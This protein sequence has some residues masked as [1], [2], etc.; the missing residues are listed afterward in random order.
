MDIVNNLLLGL[1]QAAFSFFCVS[2]YLVFLHCFYDT[3]YLWHKKK[4]VCLA[5]CV[6]LEGLLAAFSLR[7][8]SLGILSSVISLVSFLLKCFLVA[9][10]YPGKKLRA[11][12][13]F[14]L[15]STIVETC[16]GM[17][18][19]SGAALFLPE[20]LYDNFAWAQT[21]DYF[22]FS[23][24]SYALYTAIF[25]VIFLYLYHRLY[26]KGITVRCGIR[27]LIFVIL[28]PIVCLSICGVVL[29]LGKQSDLT[30]ILLTAMSMLLAI[31]FP[32]FVYYTRIGQYYRE[33]T[34]CQENYMQEELAHFTQYKLAQEETAR[35]RHDIRNNLLCLNDMLQSDETD[36]AR[37]YLREL[38][39]VSDTLRAKFVSGDEMLDCIVGVKAGI[40]EENGIRFQ[41]DGVLAGGLPWKSVDI[42]V[43]FA[44]ALDNAIEAC[45][46]LPAEDRQIAM[47]IK[48]TPQFWFVSITNP[49]KDRV[50]TDKLFR[51]DSGYT[52]KGDTRHHGI[53]TYSMKHT[54]ESCGGLV[55]AHCRDGLFTLEIAIDKN[56][57]QAA[58]K[59]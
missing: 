55:T 41:L 45:A 44:N 23:Y 48:S 32:V 13:R 35:F 52:S 5:L 17:I 38:L 7:I 36:K 3:G 29:V 1:L 49:V 11:L 24:V 28:Y 16:A 47:C 59:S 42:C 58:P 33:R 19:E 2:A 39:D 12:L 8:D 43:V 18:I 40:M 46:R 20:M 34:V 57:G 56:N 51:K 6:I 25:A 54:V 4:A 50:D 30:L 14:L 53:G 37:T 31:V 9:Y 10:D 22:V 26:T 27:E 15:L 21:A